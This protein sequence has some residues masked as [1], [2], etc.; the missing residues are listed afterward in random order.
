M[1]GRWRVRAYENFGAPGEGEVYS[2]G[3]FPCKTQARAAACAHVRSSLRD[4]VP[5]AVSIGDLIQL[6][7]CF[8]ESVGVWTDDSLEMVDFSG[9]EYALSIA[10]EVFSDYHESAVDAR[11][12]LTHI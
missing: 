11:N 8:G 3:D 9:Y 7:S 10:G 12:R 2:V 6:Y 5:Q 4:F 1:S